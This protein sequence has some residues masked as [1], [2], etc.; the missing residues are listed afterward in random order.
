MCGKRH[1]MR[2]GKVARIAV[3]IAAALM[4][5]GAAA[6]DA[7]ASRCDEAAAHI[8]PRA[9]SAP[10][11]AEFARRVMSMDERER[12]LAI[13]RALLDGDLP[14]FLRAAV[15]VELSGRGA[16]GAVTR[17]TL[18]VLPD[19]LAIGSS[20]DYLLMP[21]ALGTA[22][23][24]ADA[25]GFILPT[26]RMVDAIYR[27][28]ALRLAPQPL[29][30]GDAMRSTAY[31]LRHDALVRAQ[32]ASAGAAPGALTAGHKKDLVITPRLWTVP[33]RVAIYGWH[34]D[35]GAPIQPLSTFHG[36]QYADYSHGVRLVG[37]VAYVD[38]APRSI[39]ELVANPRFAPILS[40]EG[41]LAG[42]PQALRTLAAEGGRQLAALA[43]GH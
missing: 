8:P 12:D 29:P 21:M 17:V 2:A 3:A 35:A 7:E 34:R 14:R 43:A 16:D 11:G 6:A 40:D 38:G 33:G 30:A 5:R 22:L 37:T 32:R 20:N 24:V 15:P 39:F 25:F 18:C 36:A 27:Q 41:P 10:G 26:R 28:A 9:P 13:R 31:Y 23:A 19:Y 4:L 42:L 1:T